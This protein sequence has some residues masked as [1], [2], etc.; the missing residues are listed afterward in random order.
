ML[1]KRS[2]IA[3]ARGGLF[4]RVGGAAIANWSPAGVGAERKRTSKMKVQAY[5]CHI[6]K[7]LPKIILC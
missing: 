2:Q 4:E 1:L 6:T 7:G 5:G 3:S